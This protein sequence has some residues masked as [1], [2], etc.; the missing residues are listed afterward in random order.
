L[1]YLHLNLQIV[2][3]EFVSHFQS[4]VGELFCLSLILTYICCYVLPNILVQ[5]EKPHVKV[6]E[7]SSRHVTSVGFDFSVRSHT[8][9]VDDI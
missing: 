3:I 2:R 1:E 4:Y 8:V 5:V 6:F 7:F 9:L